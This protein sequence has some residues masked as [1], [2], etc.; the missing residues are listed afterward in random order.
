MTNVILA[1]ENYIFH[2]FSLQLSR[3]CPY[4]FSSLLRSAA[5]SSRTSSV[6]QN[7][8]TSSVVG[9]STRQLILRKSAG[10]AL[11]GWTHSCV[12]HLIPVHAQKIEKNT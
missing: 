1:C 2:T 6:L 10:S 9:L 8:N 11:R 12:G 7:G 3:G 5:T 4:L